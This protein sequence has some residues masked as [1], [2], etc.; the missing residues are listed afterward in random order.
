MDWIIR[1]EGCPARLGLLPGS[2]NPPTRAHVALVEAALTIVDAAVFILPRAFPHKTFEGATAEQRL[3]M[4]RRV[5][6]TRSRVAVAVAANGLFIDIAREIREDY[7]K[8]EIFVICGRD[9]AERFV[10]WDYGESGAAERMLCEFGLLVAARAG[11]YDPPAHVAH[12]VRSLVTDS[13]DD[14]SSTRV[15]SEQAIE[16]V[17]E[18]IA[19]MVR[20][21]YK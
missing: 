12:A 11:G 21:I 5:A 10:T 20:Q 7:P 16:L 1:P 13:L 17:P 19:D 3:E 2:F 14:C 9:A 8:A 6:S 15:R 18:E 4:L